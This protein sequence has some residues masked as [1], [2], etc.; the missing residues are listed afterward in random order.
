[1]LIKKQANLSNTKTLILKYFCTLDAFTL[2]YQVFT[3]NVSAY[4]KTSKL[5]WQST[6][7][8]SAIA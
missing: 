3:K 1:M 8:L 5:A 6:I 2:G 4:H 7:A